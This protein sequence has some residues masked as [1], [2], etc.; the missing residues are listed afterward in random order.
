MPIGVYKHKPHQ[1]FQKGHKSYITTEVAKRI[2]LAHIGIKKPWIKGRPK[3][4]KVSLETKKRISESHKGMKK[5]WAG[6]SMTIEG[7]KRLNAHMSKRMLENPLSYWLGK[8]RPDI[9]G[10]KHHYWIKDRTH[11]N[12]MARIRT[13]TEYLEWR[14]LVFERDNY[15]CRECRIK[16]VKVQQVT[17]NAD[18]IKP[19]A[20][21][22]E[23][24]FDV[25]NG[26]T[27]CKPCHLKQDT[28]G[29]PKL[30][31]EKVYQGKISK[32]ET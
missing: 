12:E 17:L 5:P 24:R 2:S 9:T 7:R 26:R 10:D 1:G 31:R 23:S 27:L 8:K 19:F 18:H 15:T 21:Y 13:S 11:A 6:K 4:H 14:K 25:D 20:F 28:H 29:R 30:T 32:L 3:G 16:S 22:P